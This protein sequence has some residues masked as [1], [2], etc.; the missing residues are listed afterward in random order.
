[1]RMKI[2]VLIPSWITLSEHDHQNQATSSFDGGWGNS[3]SS[4]RQKPRSTL[5]GT[6]WPGTESEALRPHGHYNLFGNMVHLHSFGSRCLKNSS[7]VLFD[8]PKVSK[9]E[10]GHVFRC[11][12]GFSWPSL[13][14][15]RWPRG[16]RKMWSW[17]RGSL[18]Q[19]PYRKRPVKSAALQ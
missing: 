13:P 7:F 10:T 16:K 5:S 4:W 8:A 12:H 18:S 3:L 11:G 14:L 1:M 17:C 2:L 19:R 15:Y 9:R 6:S